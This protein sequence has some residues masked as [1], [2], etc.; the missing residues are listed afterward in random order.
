ML[1]NLCCIVMIVV[2]KLQWEHFVQPLSYSGWLSC[3]KYPCTVLSWHFGWL[4]IIVVVSFLL[5]YMCLTT[6]MFQFNCYVVCMFFS[7]VIFLDPRIFC[8]PEEL[9]TQKWMTVNRRSYGFLICCYVYVLSWSIV[10]L[11]L[12]KIIISIVPL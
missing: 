5:Q 6:K 7:C 1:V 9:A 8:N 11:A 12:C 4:I 3:E 10:V 2:V